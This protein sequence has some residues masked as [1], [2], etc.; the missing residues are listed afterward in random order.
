MYTFENFVTTFNN[1]IQFPQANTDTVS[2]GTVR[3][4]H[5]TVT[6]L[7]ASCLNTAH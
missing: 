3:Q 1:N 2:K 4:T 7:S 5:Y 6:T